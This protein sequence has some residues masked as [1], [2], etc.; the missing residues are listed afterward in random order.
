V[1][2]PPLGLVDEEYPVGL[3]HPHRGAGA[4]RLP[5]LHPRR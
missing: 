2:R 1:T 3:S 5:L 4:G